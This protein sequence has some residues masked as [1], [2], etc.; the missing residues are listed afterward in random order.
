[1]IAELQAEG[2]LSRESA[3]QMHE[4]LR[5][6]RRIGA[7]IGV[8]MASLNVTEEAAFMTL[9]EACKRSNR[10]LRDIAE[11]V[12]HDLRVIDLPHQ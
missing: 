10:K 8:V 2:V 7:A 3:Q 6:S 11:E 1:M 9:A 5:S 4:A 12:V